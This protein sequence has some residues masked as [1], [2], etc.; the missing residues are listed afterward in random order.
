MDL[1][2]SDKRMVVETAR[3]LLDAGVSTRVEC[4]GVRIV[5]SQTAQRKAQICVL[6]PE[7]TSSP[8]IDSLDDLKA[9]EFFPDPVC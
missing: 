6:L 1:S 8:R 5:V 4:A 3:A 7:G 9:R 2:D